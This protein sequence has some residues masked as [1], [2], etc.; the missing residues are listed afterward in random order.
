MVGWGGS[1]VRRRP[2][3]RVGWRRLR[4]A[5]G[6]AGEDKRRLAWPCTEDSEGEKRRGECGGVGWLF[7]AEAARQGRG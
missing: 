2:H 7:E 1:S 5:L 4:L 3:R 6:A